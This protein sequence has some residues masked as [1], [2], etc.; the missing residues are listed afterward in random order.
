VPDPPELLYITRKFP[1]SVGGM[2]LLAASV[3]EA[4]QGL[5]PTRSIALGRSQRHLPWFLPVAAARTAWSLGHRDVDWVVCGDPVVLTALSPVLRVSEAKVAAIVHGLDLVFPSALY[6]RVTRHALRRAD[7]VLAISAAT[8]D[9]AVRLGVEPSKLTTL[10]PGLPHPPAGDRAAA[11]H[12]LRG[13]F[14]LP[15]DSFVVATVGRLVPRKGV[16]FFVSEVLPNL[17]DTVHYLV[18]GEGPERGPIE[19]AAA[20]AGVS[21]RVHLLG[22][23]SDALRDAV[24]DGTDV[25]SMPNLSRPGDMEGFGLVALEAALRGAPV[26]AARIDG[27]EHAL[28]G[29]T[30][31][32]LCAPND[33]SDWLAR[34]RPLVDGDRNRLRQDGERFRRAAQRQFSPERMRAD[35]A[36]ALTLDP[37]HS[38]LDVVIDLVEEAAGREN[39]GLWLVG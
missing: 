30:T 27:L 24:F 13:L 4:L 34:L 1:P 31:G 28:N 36:A 14:G 32:W 5:R 26:V 15:P 9:K 37:L 29:G 33:P 20:A 25:V 7:R 18:A 21:D 39:G 35:L 8:A 19:R 22:R 17:P 12:Q 11:G 23:V 6:R 2:E 38:G 10:H 16:R 3:H